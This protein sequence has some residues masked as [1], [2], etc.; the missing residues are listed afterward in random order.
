MN[1]KYWKTEDI[2]QFKKR[3]LFLRG[4]VSGNVDSMGNE[5]LKQSRQDSSGDLSNVPIHLADIGT[6]NFDRDLTIEL[7]ENAEEGL[8]SIDLALEKIENNTYGR[9]DACGKMITKARLYAIPFAKHC[10]GC[11]RDEEVEYPGGDEME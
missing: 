10:I 4:K 7:I 3:L 9:C 1:N 11:Q 2:D 8:R 5:A 6:D